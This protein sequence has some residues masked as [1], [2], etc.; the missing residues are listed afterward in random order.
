MYVA[1]VT[2]YPRPICKNV[3]RAIG[4]F[5]IYAESAYYVTNDIPDLMHSNLCSDVYVESPFEE[6]TTARFWEAR[7]ATF[8]SGYLFHASMTT[9]RN[10]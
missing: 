5:P 1:V 2:L 9:G 3:Q 4:S 10:G 7:A 6:V 8:P